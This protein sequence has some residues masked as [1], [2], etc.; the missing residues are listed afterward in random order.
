MVGD[1]PLCDVAG[2]LRAGM[3]AVWKRSD[4]LELLEEAEPSATV[5]RA[6]RHAGSGAGG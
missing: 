4:R 5:D 1:D 3:R 6:L 2:A